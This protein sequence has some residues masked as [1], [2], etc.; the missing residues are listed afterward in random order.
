MLR[1]LVEATGFTIAG[2]QEAGRAGLG[3]RELLRQHRAA[4]RRP[5]WHHSQTAVFDRR[6]I[7]RDVD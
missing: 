7:D 5:T 2:R 3:G 4:L 6:V 1:N